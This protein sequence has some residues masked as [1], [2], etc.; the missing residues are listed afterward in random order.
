MREAGVKWKTPGGDD[1]ERQHKRLEVRRARARNFIY[2]QNMQRKK[3][4]QYF[5]LD[6]VSIWIYNII[7]FIKKLV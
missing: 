4:C 1:Q 6:L 3:K 5:L 7:C 2:K